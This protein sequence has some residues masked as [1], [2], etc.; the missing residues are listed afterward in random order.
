MSTG[1]VTNWFPIETDPVHVGV[2]ERDLGGMQ[3]Y[4]HWNGMFWGSSEMT[5][6]MA[7]EQRDDMATEQSAAWR[8][9]TEPAQ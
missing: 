4:S 9:L 1:E 8:G 5:P 3:F 2:Y 6:D 7:Y